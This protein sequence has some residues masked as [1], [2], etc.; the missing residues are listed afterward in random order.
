VTAAFTAA[1]WA[2]AVLGGLGAGGAVIALLVWARRP[3]RPRPGPGTGRHRSTP[4]SIACPEPVPGGWTPVIYRPCAGVCHP[5]G[6]RAAALTPHELSGDG[7]ATCVTCGGT[8][9]HP[10]AVLEGALL[11]D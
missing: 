9:H 3:G 10:R 7:T 4:Y 2:L 8:H 6:S 1:R 5:V 11:D